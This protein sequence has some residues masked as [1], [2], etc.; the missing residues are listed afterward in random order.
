MDYNDIGWGIF[1]GNLCRFID[2]IDAEATS[3][4]WWHI[5]PNESIYG[6]FARSIKLKD[7]KGGI[8]F[9]VNDVFAKE[10][11]EVEIRIVWLD[12]GLGEW[13]VFYNTEK[14]A[15]KSL[16]TVKNGNTGKWME[17]TVLVKDA[18]FA[19]KGERSSDIY[20]T[21]KSNE[22]CIFHLIEVTK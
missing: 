17:K 18:C 8:Y 20:I 13:T 14:K 4:G 10:C 12:K 9:D 15:D 7:G 5:G 6:R 11:K 2:Q 22:L 19:N 21:S 16:F 3:D 1:D